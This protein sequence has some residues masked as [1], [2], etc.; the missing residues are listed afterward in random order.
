MKVIEQPKNKHYTKNS[1]INL[2]IVALN[3]FSTNKPHTREKER[4]KTYTH[5]HANIQTATKGPKKRKIDVLMT[6]H[7]RKVFFFICLQRNYPTND[8][9]KQKSRKQRYDRM[10]TAERIQCAH[11]F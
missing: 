4:K 6:F 3:E 10:Y 5:M 1:V 8:E 9:G 2:T 11:M 7:G